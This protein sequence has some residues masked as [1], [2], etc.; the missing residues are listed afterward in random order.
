MNKIQNSKIVFS[1]VVKFVFSL[2]Y[3]SV[4]EI[5]K[6][7]FSENFKIMLVQMSRLYNKWLLNMYEVLIVL[8]LQSLFISVCTLITVKKSTL[9][10]SF[11]LIR[12]YSLQPFNIS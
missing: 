10:F 7:E 9:L 12:Y 1:F 6:Y 4:R 3:Y 2:Q 8:E 5:I 11:S